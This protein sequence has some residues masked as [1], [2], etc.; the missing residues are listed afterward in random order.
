MGKTKEGWGQGRTSPW[1]ASSE[2]EREGEWDMELCR[3]ERPPR[4]GPPSLDK[5]RRE[6]ESCWVSAVIWLSETY[7]TQQER[8]QT[9]V[10]VV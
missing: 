6:G 9:C 2:L 10:H 8:S 1:G 4:A 7:H 3:E 5:E